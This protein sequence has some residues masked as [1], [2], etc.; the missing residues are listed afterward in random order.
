MTAKI[1]AGRPNRTIEAHHGAICEALSRV[2]M[3]PEP[4]G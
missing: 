1:E 4:A 2:S 3:A